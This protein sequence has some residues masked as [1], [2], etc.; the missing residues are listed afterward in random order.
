[1]ENLWGDFLDYEIDAETPIVKS[2]LQASLLGPKVKN[3]L[4]ASVTPLTARERK[5]RLLP[6]DHLGFTFDIYAPCLDLR[7]RVFTATYPLAGFPMK[8][9]KWRRTSGV[10]SENIDEFMAELADILG[11]DRMKKTL[12]SLLAQSMPSDGVD[13]NGESE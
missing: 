8:I 10:S 12:G 7:V 5:D 4:T 3:L 11:S 13:L 9:S 6:S 2:R 1:M